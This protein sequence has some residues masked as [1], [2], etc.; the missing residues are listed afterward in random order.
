V[1]YSSG[2]NE[3]YTPPK[4]IES[5][6]KTMGI[7]DVDPASSKIANKVVNATTY[8]TKE[9]NGLDN[10]WIGNVW[11]NP[12]YAQP[13]INLFSKALEKNLNNKTKQANCIGK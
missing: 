4:F 1:S 10:D 7:I 12:P 9:T 2:E 6:R 11:M 3:W 8:Y 5:A 13:L